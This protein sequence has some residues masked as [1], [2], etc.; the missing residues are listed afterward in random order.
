[1]STVDSASHHHRVFVSTKAVYGWSLALLLVCGALVA[2]FFV[3][4]PL[5]QLHMSRLE[6]LVT[7][8]AL[9]YGHELLHLLAFRSGGGVP[10][11]QIAIRL[12]PRHFLP[13]VELRVPVS[14]GRLRV[15]ALLP[16]VLLGVVPLVAGAL[17]GSGKLLVIGALM[18]AAAGGDVVIVAAVHGLAPG[19]LVELG[20]EWTS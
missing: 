14:V 17:A 3:H 4:H 9:L 12:S 2:P 19:T 20:A 5:Q 13:Y 8:P 18:T 11:G 7:A 1:M 10:R 16:G 15:A 6:R